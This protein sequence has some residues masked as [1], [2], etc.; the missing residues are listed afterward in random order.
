MRRRRTQRPRGMSTTDDHFP[1]TFSHQFR[2]R[3]QGFG[4]PRPQVPDSIDPVTRFEEAFAEG[5]RRT[6]DWY[7][8][9]LKTSYGGWVREWPF[10]CPP[11][12]IM[13]RRKSGRSQT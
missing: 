13:A 5:L 12:R 4:R 6:I 9:A 11:R 8:W 2:R 10:G 1:D 3:W 7:R